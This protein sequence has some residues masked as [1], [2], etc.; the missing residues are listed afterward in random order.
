[1]IDYSA[2]EVHV[3][4]LSANATVVRFFNTRRYQIDDGSQAS[5]SSRPTGL[6]DSSPSRADFKVEDGIVRF[7]FGDEWREVSPE[8]W[9]WKPHP[10]SYKRCY[11]CSFVDA[12]GHVD[13][14]A[15][16][17]RYYDFTVWIP[18]V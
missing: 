4:S 18:E 7:K 2:L 11:K 16:P 14:D 10:T 9:A 5:E 17:D 13:Y 12:C 1:M 3:V 15:H 6:P 8:R